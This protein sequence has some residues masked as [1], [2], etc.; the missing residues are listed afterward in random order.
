MDA[1]W[2]IWIE[3]QEK[4]DDV[5]VEAIEFDDP[6]L[7]MAV[8]DKIMLRA[9]ILPINVLNRKVTWESSDEAI[10]T[11][12]EK[13]YLK[14]L[15]TGEATITATSVQNPDISGSCTVYVKMSSDMVDI[16]PYQRDARISWPGYNPD[17][18][19]RVSWRRAGETEWNSAEPQ[20]ETKIYLHGLLPDTEYEGTVK[21]IGDETTSP[22]AFTFETNP[23]TSEYP[24]IE[25]SKKRIKA[26]EAIPLIVSNIADD[27]H[28]IVWKVNGSV[29]D[30]DEYECVKSGTVELRAEISLDD[31]ST[32]VLINELEVMK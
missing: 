16:I 4:V 28:T 25:L 27:E 7:E 21:A 12:D 30:G 6:T 23:L 32:E 31:G 18:E 22:V 15:A 1:N 24:V 11:I 20:A 5:P 19:W 10:A 13:G 14:A 29:I 8:G 26:G 17:C 3:L 9:N 2:A